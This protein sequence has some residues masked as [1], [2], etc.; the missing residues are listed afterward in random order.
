[1]WSFHKLEPVRRSLGQCRSIFMLSAF[2]LLSYGFISDHS[3][4]TEP[5][6]LHPLPFAVSSFGAVATQDSIFVFGGHVAPVHEWSKQAVI[7]NFF[8]L[9]LKN[10][11]NSTWTTLDQEQALQ[12]MNIVAYKKNIYRVGGM[13]PQNEKGED[14]DNFSVKTVSRYSLE[15]KQWEAFKPLPQ[16]RSSHDVILN[17]GRLFTIGGWDMQGDSGGQVWCD[18]IDCIDLNDPDAEWQSIHQPFMRRALI[19]AE[20]QDCI[21]VIGGF[22]DEEEITREVNIY[23]PKNNSWTL[24]PR[25]PE[26]QFNGFASAACVFENQ[27]IVNVADGT[28]LKLSSDHEHWGVIT[29]VSPRIVH[30]IVPANSGVVLIGGAHNGHNLDTVEFITIP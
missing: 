15:K 13:E 30:R 6:L 26:G 25:L 1:M 3:F 24:G 4:G 5:T 10:I 11:S 12:G 14:A 28:L 20:F 2:G 29:K 7:G 21:W 16:P 18:T 8:K 27:L 17:N 23:N 22:T 9:D 19:A